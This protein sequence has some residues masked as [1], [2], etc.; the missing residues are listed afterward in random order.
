[1]KIRQR[2]AIL[3]AGPIG[4]EA[5]V[6]AMSY[7]HR[8][9]VF[10]LGEPGESVR[11]WGHVRMFSPFGM[12]VSLR[13]IERLKKRQQPL[14]DPDELL[15]GTEF[16]AQYL[17]PLAESLGEEILHTN[18][19]VVAVGR[20]EILKKDQVGEP[21]RM[22]SGFRLLLRRGAREWAED[23]E[24]VFD[25]TGT[26]Q[27]PN[28]L[29]DGGIPAVGESAAKS[30]ISYGPVDLL[31]RQRRLYENRRVLVVGSGYSAATA[32]RDLAEL[33]KTAPETKIIWAARRDVIP[34]CPRVEDDPLP[35]RDQLAALVND[36]VDSDGI[37]FRRESTVLALHPGEE[38]LTV[39][40]RAFGGPAK[41]VVDRIIAA[42]GFRPELDMTRELQTHTSYATEG[43]NRLAAV[44]E[45]NS[46]DDCFETGRCGAETLLHPEPGYFTLG[47]KSFGR[48][49]NFFLR[50]GRAQVDAVLDWIEKQ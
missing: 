12:N 19:E 18:V 47:M 20:G 15:T 31:G 46:T 42:V 26:F 3:G 21:S 43:A 14:P 33:R 10:E 40:L 23:A 24:I 48:A 2:I 30:F 8:V 45:T 5:A 41:I 13:G 16:V 37:D 22:E 7:G 44:M 35:E 9:N 38:G 28:P 29:G 39:T 27:T 1:M 25:C 49:S 32:V 17:A 6:A 34:P 50:Q 11:R 36:L 4:L